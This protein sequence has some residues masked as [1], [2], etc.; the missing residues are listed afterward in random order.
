MMPI[1]GFNGAWQRYAYAHLAVSSWRRAVLQYLPNQNG[2][3]IQRQLPTLCLDFVADCLFQGVNGKCERSALSLDDVMVVLMPLCG[4]TSTPWGAKD[5]AIRAV[6]MIAPLP[7]SIFMSFHKSQPGCPACH[8]AVALK[9]ACAAQL[10]VHFFGFIFAP[11]N[12][13]IFQGL[14]RAS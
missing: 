5:A 1:A 3:G 12:D 14:P 6:C 13:F 9:P 7:Y 2:R 11:E 4:C 10:W 8:T